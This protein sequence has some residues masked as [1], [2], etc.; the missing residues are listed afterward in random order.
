MFTR[1]EQMVKVFRDHGYEVIDRDGQF[2]VYNLHWQYDVRNGGSE[3]SRERIGS[4]IYNGLDKGPA[5]VPE[6]GVN[7]DTLRYATRVATQHLDRRPID[8][9]RKMVSGDINEDGSIVET[10]DKL[11]NHGYSIESTQDSEGRNVWNI[12]YTR[13][14]DRKRRIVNPIGSE[15]IG[16]IVDS[17][18]GSYWF[19]SGHDPIED[20]MV[21]SRAKHDAALILV[22]NH[23]IYHRRTKNSNV[24]K[25]S[26]KIR[27]S[28]CV[29]NMDCYDKACLLLDLSHGFWGKY[30]DG[31]H[32]YPEIRESMLRGGE[33]TADHVDFS[34]SLPKGLVLPKGYVR[35]EW[36]QKADNVS[37]T[38]DGFHAE[39]GF[40]TR[41]DLPPSGWWVPFK[42]GPNYRWFHPLTGSPLETV[43]FDEKERAIQ[44]IHDAGHDSTDLSA[45]RRS[46]KR[47]RTGTR[48]VFRNNSR[49]GRGPMYVGILYNPERTSKILGFRS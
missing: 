42:D 27:N 15:Y 4:I 9:I 5:F 3:T 20:L 41:V 31:N 19:F 12:H 18:V 8:V 33:W 22:D 47:R 23:A 17:G 11:E 44:R 7:G 37:Q 29:P 35:V 14:Q 13:W 48:N 1:T 46:L 40:R 38:D 6:P 21:T 49:V 24:V 16:S 36:I 2:G 26:T 32:R 39:G 34:V 25:I 45:F 28:E 43:P 30:R 10:L